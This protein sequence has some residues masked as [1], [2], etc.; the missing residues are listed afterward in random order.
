MSHHMDSQDTTNQRSI[1]KAQS[2]NRNKTGFSRAGEYKARDS[3]SV[4]GTRVGEKE[5][6]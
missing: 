1:M 5:T 2:L 6:E 4:S 3:L